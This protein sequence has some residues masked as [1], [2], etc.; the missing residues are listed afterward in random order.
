MK[1]KDLSPGQVVSFWSDT[2]QR[3]GLV[4]ATGRRLVHVAHLRS[5]AH[6]TRTAM[7]PQ[8][9]TRLHDEYNPRRARGYARRLLR[10]GGRD[11][12][13]KAARA[14]LR[15]IIEGACA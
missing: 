8:A 6:V 10:A 1:P 12:V 2:G 5:A 9:I 11:G 4:V 3:V 13:T 14:G 15:G 7:D